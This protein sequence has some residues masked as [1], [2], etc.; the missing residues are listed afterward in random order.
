MADTFTRLDQALLRFMNGTDFK[1]FTMIL[2]AAGFVTSAMIGS[3][4]ALNFAYIVYLTLRR[5][6]V[7]SDQIG[8]L[9]R[10]WFVMS[11][12][13]GR[14]TGSAETAFGADIQALNE[15][16][17]ADALAVVEQ[18]DL[19]EAFWEAGL[20]QQMSSSVRTN[21]AFSVFLASQ[22]KA[23]DK[24]FLSRNHTVQI[25]LQGTSHVHHVFPQAYLKAKGLPRNRYNQIANYVVMQSEINIAVGGQPPADYFNA[26]AQQCTTCT[27]RYGGITDADALRENLQA[28][29]IPA[30]ME[31]VDI[32]GYDAF[33]RERR[34]LM[35][36]K[37]C[38]YYASL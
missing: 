30:G 18:A 8:T 10:R 22:V 14:Y 12:L 9:V 36:R 1:R 15:Q 4:N 37:I 25:L 27:P 3:Q 38:D 21:P 35:A 23:Q 2:R 13:T 34:A 29:C 11:V 31:T 32:D 19:S 17:V 5:Q 24:G 33:L 26:L 16:G 7:A 20:P 28:H 6:G